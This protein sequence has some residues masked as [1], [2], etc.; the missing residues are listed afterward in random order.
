MAIKDKEIP[1]P[2]SPAIFLSFPWLYILEERA[3]IRDLTFLDYLLCTREL[4]VLVISFL[5]F[6][7]ILLLLGSIFY[8]GDKKEELRC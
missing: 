8:R 2:Q 6:A 1:A 3:W 7:K 5:T 4:Y